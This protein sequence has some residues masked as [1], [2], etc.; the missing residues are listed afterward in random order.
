MGSSNA[1]AKRRIFIVEDHGVFRQGLAWIIDK[2]NEM[3]VCGD[4]ADAA[5]ALQKIK[6]LTP[7]LVLVDIGLAG[8]SGI[9]LTKRLRTLAPEMRILILSMH[10]ES[11]YAEHSLRAG[12]HGYIMKRES[13]EELI[14]AMRRV[15]N[16][17]IYVSKR[18]NEILLQ[19]VSGAGRKVR[20]FS[21]DLLTE[22]EMEVL[23]R[24]GQG[25]GTR[26][27][28]EELGI[29][30]KTVEAHKEHIRAKLGLSTNAELVQHAIHLVHSESD[31][32]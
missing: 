20:Q 18:F 23:Q 5:E 7:D 11:L 28:A 2:S 15:L 16:G 21:I 14:S 1:K 10:K 3:E 13:G 6:E 24:V 29:S 32:K 8:M 22:R 31:F 12:A 27:I 4:A 19:K 30:M 26:Q 25:L 17:E 9:E